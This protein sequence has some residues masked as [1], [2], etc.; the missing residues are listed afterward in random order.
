[1]N[2]ANTLCNEDDKAFQS[3]I[4]M[5]TFDSLKDPEEADP[6]LYSEWVVCRELLSAL[7]PDFASILWEDKLDREAI[8]DCA[9]FLQRA[10]G[11]K[12]DRNANMWAV[13]LYFMLMI[14]CMFQ[15]SAA[16]H[17]SRSLCG[18]SSR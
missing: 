3:R 13:L 6:N 15:A 2:L 8:Q 18:W 16:K 4:L 14:N 9:W 1:M 7:T 17:R 5:I 11:R 10:I 12:R